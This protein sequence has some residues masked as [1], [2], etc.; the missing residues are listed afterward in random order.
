ML[1]S[2]VFKQLPIFLILLPASFLLFA[3]VWH[4]FVDETLYHCID[5]FPI[6][7]FFPPFVHEEASLGKDYFIASP[8]IVYSLWFAFLV[9]IF[10]MPLVI[11]RLIQFLQKIFQFEKH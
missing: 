2:A 6:G 10:A 1:K 4:L 7:D 11:I 5:H 3:I 8:V 9:G